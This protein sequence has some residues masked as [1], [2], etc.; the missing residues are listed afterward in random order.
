MRNPTLHQL[1]TYRRSH[2]T[3]IFSEKKPPQLFLTL[4]NHRLTTTS[5]PL[6]FRLPSG[7]NIQVR[8]PG[9]NRIILASLVNSRG[10]RHSA[11]LFPPLLPF[12]HV[13][14]KPCLLTC[15]PSNRHRNHGYLSRQP[16]QEGRLWRQA[17]LLPFVSPDMIKYT[18][19]PY[20]FLFLCEGSI[21][22]DLRQQ[23]R[24]ALSSS[25]AR[26]PT[27]VSVTSASTP[28]APAAA[29]TST[30]PSA[31]TAV[32]SPGAPRAARARPA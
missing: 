18:E 23:G 1:G 8:I 26:P 20:R 21:R 24:S 11:S 14:K 4:P 32:T 27:P 15:F 28:S 7:E 6:D 29:T 5:P 16:S 17:L 12:S 3:I 22:S 10:E 13:R 25:A 2:N 30:A 31:S 19:S 9:M